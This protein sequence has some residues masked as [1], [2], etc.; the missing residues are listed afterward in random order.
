VGAL[1]ER[2]SL[3]KH[4]EPLGWVSGRDVSVWA[5]YTPDRGQEDTDA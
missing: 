4:S 3:Y 5:E 2:K 1:V